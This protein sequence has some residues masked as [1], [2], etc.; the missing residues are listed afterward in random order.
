MCDGDKLARA[1][2]EG[3]KRQSITD[4]FPAGRANAVALSVRTVIAFDEPEFDEA[5]DVSAECP[6]VD[7][8]DALANRVVGRENRFTMAGLQETEHGLKCLDMARTQ[9]EYATCISQCPEDGPDVGFSR[10]N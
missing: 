3:G 10:R 2:E 1:L 6:F 8:A 5:V 4:A 7:S 9:T